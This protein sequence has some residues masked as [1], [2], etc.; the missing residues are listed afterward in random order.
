MTIREI[1]KKIAD[2]LNGVEELVQGGCKAL[3]ED[4]QD[5]TER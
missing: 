5:E 3:A 4:A 1:Q 2:A